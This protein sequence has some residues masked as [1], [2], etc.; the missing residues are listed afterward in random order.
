MQVRAAALGVCLDW[1]S[2]AWSYRELHVSCSG[3]PLHSPT[4]NTQPVEQITL[5]PNPPNNPYHQSS[6]MP[7]RGSV[8]VKL[9]KKEET[10]VLQVGAMTIRVYEDGSLTQ[11]RVSGVL[12]EVPAG[13]SGPPMHWHRFHDELFFVTKGWYQPL[14]AH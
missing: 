3:V 1:A 4:D 6:N 2:L 8:P 5:Q 12:L 13:K 7:L 9:Y 11:D 14:N 10:E